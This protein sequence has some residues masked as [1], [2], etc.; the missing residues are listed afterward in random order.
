ML[1]VLA[2]RCL[3]TLADN[4][5]NKEKLTFEMARTVT[6]H[7]MLIYKQALESHVWAGYEQTRLV[8]DVA[9]AGASTP[10]EANAIEALRP[11]FENLSEDVLAAW[12]GAGTAYATSLA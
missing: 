1:S 3:K 4:D 6:A 10:T 8:Y 7:V 5:D 12:V 11:A 9:R 2:Q